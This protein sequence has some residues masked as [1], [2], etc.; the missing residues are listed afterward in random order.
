MA[1]TT[2]NIL[3]SKEKCSG[4]KKAKMKY[5]KCCILAYLKCTNTQ[6]LN[7]DSTDLTKQQSGNLF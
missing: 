1:K 4:K 7:N 2:V 5:K 3:S 6:Q